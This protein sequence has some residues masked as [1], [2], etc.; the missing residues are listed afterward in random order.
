MSRKLCVVNFLVVCCALA[1][2]ARTG[3]VALPSFGATLRP[4]HS[5]TVDFDRTRPTHSV[6]A[7]ARSSNQHRTN[8][9]Q[10]SSR[11]RPRAS[12]SL[13]LTFEPAPKAAGSATQFIG[14]GRGMTILLQNRG[15]AVQVP[16]RRAAATAQDH[17]YSRAATLSIRVT[18]ANRSGVSAAKN[19]SWQGEE[20]LRGV[21]NYFIGRNP[22]TWRM[23]VPHFAVAESSEAALGV[24]LRVYGNDEGA[25]YDLRLAPATDASA[26]RL[27]LSGARDLHLDRDGSLSL[28]LAG[29]TLVMKKPRIYQQW[30]AALPAN[31]AN[32]PAAEAPPQT[33][34]SGGYVLHADGTVG[35]RIGP[36]NPSAEL[37]IDPSI[38]VAYVTFLGGAGA[39]SANS[40]SVDSAGSVYIAGTTTSPSSFT[41][42]PAQSVGPSGGSSVFFVA[43][44]DPGA[45]GANSLLYL[46]FLGGSGSQGGGLLALD[47]ND[48]AYIAGTTTSA[49]YPVTDNSA[50]TSG[51]NDLA[52]SELG[53]TGSTLLFSTIFGGNGAEATQQPGGISVDSSG[54][55]FFA[56]DTTSTNL[57][58]TAAAY[59]GTYGGGLSDGFL[60]IFKPGAT[61]AL[62]YC[63]YLG[64]DSQVAV[65]G[66]ALDS[67]NDAYLAGYTSNPGTT[68]PATPNALQ[69]AYQGDPSDA[70]LIEISPQGGGAA[71]LKYATLLGGGG[72]DEALGI[73]VDSASPPHVYLTGTTASANFPV[74][75]AATQP[76]TTYAAFQSALAGKANAFL[77]VIG[78]SEPTGATFLVYSSYL[79]GSQSDS[80][81]SIAIVPPAAGVTSPSTQVYIAGT[82]ASWDFPWHDNFQPFSGGT[83]AF[84]AELNSA[85]SGSA[86]R[87]YAT[88]MG[89]TARTGATSLTQGNAVAL[90]ASGDVFVAGATNAGDFPL[91]ANPGTGVQVL[92]G[93]CQESTPLPDAFLLALIQGSSPEPSVSFSAGVVRFSGEPLGTS[94]SPLPVAVINTGEAP[95]TI[96]TAP[97]IAGPNAADFSLLDS[98]GC[99]AS[100]IP[101]SG[102]CSFEV[103]FDPSVVGPESAFINLQ[104]NAPGNPQVLALQGIGNGA[105]ASPSPAALSFPSQPE[106]VASPAQTVTLTNTGNQALAITGAVFS[107]P[108]VGEF[109][110]QQGSTCPSSTSILPGDSC[111]FEISFESATAGTFHAELDVTDNSG[112]A[113]GA[114]QVIPLTG[115]AVAPV[116]VATVT[117]LSLS[118]GAQSVGS[119]SGLQTITLT[120]S[121]SAALDISATA[122]SG[123]NLT[124][125][126][127][128]SQGSAPCPVQG[129][130]VAT[131]SACTLSIRFVPQSAGAKSATVSFSDN[132]S[133]SPQTVALTGTATA[134]AVQISPTTLTFASQSVG[135]AGTPQTVTITDTGSGPLAINGVTVGGSDAS[136]F[137]ETNNCPLSLPANASCLLSVTF[138]PGAAGVRTA[139][140]G[141]ADDAPASP[142]TIGLSGTAIQTAASVSPS[143][144][145][146]A[147]QLLTTASAAVP[148]TVTNTGSVA[149]AVSGISFSG[150]DAGDFTETDNCTSNVAVSI[151]PGASCSIQVA[152]KPVVGGARSASLV[153]AD[154][155]PG[156]PQSVPL[157]G[158]GMDF[159]ITDPPNAGASATIGA[160]Q[161]ATYS[162]QIN[163]AYG[164]SGS[165]S[166][167][168]SGAPPLGACTAAPTSVAVPANG[169]AAFQ[170]SV[171]TTAGS[172]ILP[173]TRL[174]RPP[175]ELGRIACLALAITLLLFCGGGTQ[176]R[177]ARLRG[178]LPV[179]ALAIAMFVAIGIS[180]CGG[181]GR[182]SAPPSDPG[183]PSGTYPLV[184][185]AASNGVSRTI[186]LT[187]TVQ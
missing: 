161:T 48:D 33:R 21:S 99:T 82:A 103:S 169:S 152:F 39:D 31:R 19:L 34:V 117:P 170:V 93:S 97:Q 150:L 53:P 59:H 167:A 35:F 54:R 42:A 184:V 172:S 95:L 57:P 29:T 26:L 10:N 67:L 116:P 173:P 83:D 136:D 64:I 30:P 74:S 122:I 111:V 171:T 8:S 43:K 36:H 60:A 125:F 96:T 100:A 153:I 58:V 126:A 102:E 46:T 76:N 69:S 123:T 105:L 98:F 176:E 55:I 145:A 155:A 14:R 109:L 45:S 134:P 174:L 132:A 163:S 138:K 131:G 101:A 133:G 5:P 175:D 56:S 156:S 114:E 107:G 129:G 50:L 91:T 104:D 94:A 40:V 115:T 79:G 157:S 106:N 88:P 28:S 183:T 17:F 168:C 27:R 139:Q 41:V 144:I 13:P 146:F 89:G 179:M 187:L 38:S 166:L 164:Y 143:S 182:S 23:R 81:Q 185:T 86:S 142:Q 85:A 16:N 159:S 118:F 3:G 68:F 78:T 186:N 178:T 12:I 110:P 73:A 37:V 24:N 25:E 151:A 181:G 148:A 75:V 127:I 6:P 84:V 130:V 80:G 77:A 70:F 47:S 177:N 135:T 65:G 180:A 15:I 18:E 108:G 119:S 1:F 165:V 51:A 160:G 44:L 22:G 11:A 112:G 124:E 120:N 121:G 9:P 140:I 2:L 154:N 162:L 92:C 62:Q 7:A 71:D 49:N 20:R 113:A 158:T 147:N 66:I 61:P 32:D 128:V 90:D 4:L 63:S 72:M 87:I 141:I 149:L 52:V 137:I